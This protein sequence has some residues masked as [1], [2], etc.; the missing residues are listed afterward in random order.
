[1]RRALITV[2]VFAAPALA[3][4]GGAASPDGRWQAWIKVERPATDSDDGLDSLWLTD[5]RSGK[6]C[7]LFR[8]HLNTAAIANPH[9]SLDGRF[10]YVTTKEAPVSLGTHRIDVR[11]GT[12]R[13][14][15]VGGTVSVL[16]NGPYRG[17]LLAQPHRYWE[18]GGSY[19][20]IV[21]VRPDGKEMFTVP[22]SDKDDGAKS[23]DRWLRAKGWTAS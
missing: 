3:N 9:W 12:E 15:F 5:R 4:E 23:L 13:L 6:S 1:M 20:P 16:R 11:S 2:A 8:G 14:V 10:V 21:V 18:A 19:N 7:R 17:Y 22:G